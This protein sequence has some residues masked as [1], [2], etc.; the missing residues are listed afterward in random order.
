MLS[1]SSLVAG[2]LGS[3]SV[4]DVNQALDDAGWVLIR[5]VRKP[6]L[7]QFESLVDELV[8]RVIRVSNPSR[9]QPAADQGTR[10]VNVGHDRI[11][12]HSELATVPFCPRTIC[13]FVD[14]SADSGGETILCDGHGVLAELSSSSREW[15]RQGVLRYEVEPM[16]NDVLIHNLGVRSRQ[17]LADRL[18]DLPGVSNVYPR[19][20]RHGF[21]FTRPAVVS[22]NDSAP[23]FCNNVFTWPSI[24]AYPRRGYDDMAADAR[25]IAER[26][27]L[28]VR[29]RTGDIFALR[30]HRVMHGREAFVG[31]RTVFAR[32]GT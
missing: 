26:R 1:E 31:T 10:G 15:L 6:S 18:E 11:G 32:M 7:Q 29:Q 9:V 14:R 22:D 4:D 2:D 20:D 3:V 30:N 5:T 13:F 16:E 23:A 25:S 12:L 27:T 21:T 28:C 8:D 19:G 24:D 17:E